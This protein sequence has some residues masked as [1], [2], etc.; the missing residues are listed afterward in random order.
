MP[1][2]NGVISPSVFKMGSINSTSI[3]SNMTNPQLQKAVVTAGP[4][5]T[6]MPNLWLVMVRGGLGGQVYSF[7]SPV[8]TVQTRQDMLTFANQKIK[9]M[10][11]NPAQEIG[12]AHADTTPMPVGV[13]DGWITKYDYAVNWPFGTNQAD[14][15]HAEQHI[16]EYQYY[17]SYS[18]MAFWRV[19]S[20][21]YS[22]VPTY[23]DEISYP[24]YFH[25]GPYVYDVLVSVDATSSN[26]WQGTG[27]DPNNLSGLDC[28]SPTNPVSTTH[29]SVSLGLSGS[30]NGFGFDANWAWGWDVSDVNAYVTSSYTTPYVHT[31]EQFKQADWS[32]WWYGQV[33][34]PAYVSHAS[35]GTQYT[36]LYRTPDNQYF[37]VDQLCTTWNLKD[38][39]MIQNVWPPGTWSWNENLYPCSWTVGSMNLS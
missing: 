1:L 5:Q 13:G 6:F 3:I 32:G 38:Q 31:D 14:D 4:T 7:A 20:Y 19:D 23:S 30:D 34:E 26:Q 33:S 28:F 12:V 39:Y 15:Y 24:S 21:V 29:V 27:Y 11:A 36:S 2:N 9:E 35:F 25:V 17:D 10:I 18:N 8:D 16:S 37:P 22:S